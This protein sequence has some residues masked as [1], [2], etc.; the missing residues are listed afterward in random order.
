M[1][2]NIFDKDTPVPQHNVSNRGT[3]RFTE[4]TTAPV[5]KLIT[6]LAAPSIVIMIISGVYNLADTFFVGSL[7]T[8]EVA[9]V[10]IAFPLMAII[11]AIGFFFGQGSG[12]YMSRALGAKDT[13]NASKMAATGLLSGVLLMLV[14]AAIGLILNDKLVVWLGATPTIK[15]HAVDFILFIW[16]GSPWM[17]AATILNQQLRFQ[18][19]ASIAMIGMVSGAILNIILD[20]IFI[21]WLGMNV[22]GA[23]FATMLSQM[24]SFFILFTYTHKGRDCVRIKL[25]NF[26]PSV[27]HYRE[28]FRGGIP[29][30]LRQT[31]MSLATVVTNILAGPYGDSAIAAISI[32]N[33]VSMLASSSVLG[34]GQGFQPVCGFNYGAHLYARVKEGF[35]FC[36]KVCFAGLTVICVAM[37]IFSPEI[38]QWF[39]D[40]PEVIKIGALGLRLVCISLP[41]SA[42]IVIT[43]M[44]SQTMGKAK[45]ASILAMARQGLFLFPAMAALVPTLHLLGILL[46]TPV[47]NAA[48]FLLSIPIAHRVMTRDLSIKSIS[49]T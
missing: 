20:P 4:M 28:I 30:L 2:K 40:D 31:L 11:Q 32:V 48:S 22:K 35:W 6:K 34:F 5:H 29:S 43:S 46:C 9:A 33:R 1:E 49:D 45:E 38:V 47:A 21:F 18:G 25:K 8:S 3:D 23:A 27:K 13:S 19:S 12:N 36:I 41:F 14:I 44:M 42:G 17:V 24:L 10:G 39:R 37:I 15:P 26:S 16:L 7:G